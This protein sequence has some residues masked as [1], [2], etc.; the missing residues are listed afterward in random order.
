MGFIQYPIIFLICY[1][2]GSIP[3]GLIIGK[4]RGVDIRREGSGNIGA[5]NVVRVVGKKWGILCFILDFLKGFLPV[6]IV[7]SLTLGTNQAVSP[8]WEP[9]IAAIGAFSGHV[10][11]V[12]LGFKGGKGVATGA[13]AVLALAPLSVLCAAVLWAV[14]F[15]AFRY[16]SLASLAAAASLP[17]TA[18]LFRQL[19]VS[20]V[21]V[22]DLLLLTAIAILAIARHRSNIRRLLNG[23]ENRFGK[24]REIT[25]PSKNGES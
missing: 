17:I 23:T 8:G 16:V 1:L 12:Y 3:W 22:P 4:C 11:S 19:G 14:F 18:I 10:W 15:F 2:F 7:A 25:I 21:A 5:T 24:G 9:A 6:S 13:G 20:R